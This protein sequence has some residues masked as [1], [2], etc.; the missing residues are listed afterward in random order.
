MIT[1]NELMSDIILLLHTCKVFSTSLYRMDQINSN[2]PCFY[3]I[4]YERNKE[5]I[6]FVTIC[7]FVFL[8]QQY[9]MLKML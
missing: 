6:G 9:I 5:A 7:N 4:I 3:F 8:H 2:R 1:T